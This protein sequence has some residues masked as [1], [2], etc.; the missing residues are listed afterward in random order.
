MDINE[1][2]L[3]DIKYLSMIEEWM[4]VDTRPEI[5]QKTRHATRDA[6]W[7]PDQNDE[8][9]LWVDSDQQFSIALSRALMAYWLSMFLL[10]SPQFFR[11]SVD[12]AWISIKPC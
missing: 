2:W 5:L 9:K 10:S 8:K 3:T 4:G 7:T 12:R 1:E 6:Y 11:R